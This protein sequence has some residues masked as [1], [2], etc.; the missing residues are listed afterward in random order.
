MRKISRAEKHLKFRCKEGEL[1]DLIKEFI[2]FY[3]PHRK[4]FILD[5]SCALGIAAM[6]LIFP[7]LSR[8]ILNMYIPDR[9]L[10]ALIITAFVMLFLYLLRAVFNYVVHYWGHIVGVRIEY[11]MRKTLFDHLQ[12]QDISFFDKSRTGQ[13]MSRLVNDLNLITELAHHGPEDLFLSVIMLSGSFII[14][15][16]IEWRLTLILFAFIPFMFYFTLKKSMQMRKKFREVRERIAAVN[17]QIENSISGIRVSKAFT[18]EDYEQE[19]F[20]E[21]NMTFRISRS[22]AFKTMAEFYSG[23]NLY[24]NF[25]TLIAI[26]FGGYFVFSGRISYGDLLAFILYTNFFM[27]PL[28]RLTNFTEQFQNG[29]S[30]FER[31]REMMSVKPKIQDPPEARELVNVAGNISFRNVSFSY[32]SDQQNNILSHINIDIPAGKTVALVGPSGGGKTT[33][34]HLIPRF[35]DV[36]EGEIFIDNNNIKDFTVKSLRKSIGLVQQSVFLFTGT[37]RE[38]I[39]YGKID[40]TDE[41]VIEAAKNA[42]IHDFIASLP[43]GYETYVGERGVRLS[44]GQQQRLSIAR[45]FLK[46]PPILILD[47]A[48]SAL[49]NATEIMI[50]RSLEKLSA[51]RTTLVIA[52]RLSTIKSADEI[53]V[54]DD[55]GIHERG[56]HDDLIKLNGI[57]C[58]LYNSQFKGFM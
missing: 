40:A 3:K 37:I 16:N 42:S 41:E 34:C 11:D 57:Y 31:F 52:H 54:I 21:G 27:E 19:K 30:G 1:L 13:L 6:D 23:I 36:T 49:D 32:E 26:S 50:Q 15:L 10:R 17:S 38:N 8:N 46:N 28:K 14:L 5:I 4:I 56:T 12:T 44:G 24:M 48:T 39:L 35:Y 29:M 45:V 47:E 25:L 18:N 9:N 58:Q 55:K 33:L 43:E 7:L 20:N 51:G 53:I 22:N 2:K